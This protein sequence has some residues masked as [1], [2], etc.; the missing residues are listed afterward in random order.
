MKKIFALISVVAFLAAC[1]SAKQEEPI[2][3]DSTVI[4]D[5]A[6][7]VDTTAKK[8]TTVA[9]AKPAVKVEVKK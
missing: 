2:K 4:V 9:V 5:S 8:D 3:V 6:K 1:G 7:A